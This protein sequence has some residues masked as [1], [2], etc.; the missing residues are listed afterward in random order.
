MYLR[1]KDEKM[2]M[3]LQRCR[4]YNQRNRENIEITHYRTENCANCR[5][6]LNLNKKPCLSSNINDISV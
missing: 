2:G 4:L 6:T 1:E 5:F 3:N